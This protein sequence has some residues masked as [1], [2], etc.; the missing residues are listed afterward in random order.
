MDTNDWHEHNQDRAAKRHQNLVI[1][2]KILADAGIKF[3]SRDY[4]QHIIIKMPFRIDFWPS[5]GLW[6]TSQSKG[7]GVHELIKFIAAHAA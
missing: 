3:E 7:R 5:T 6:K 4:G 1:S 2:T